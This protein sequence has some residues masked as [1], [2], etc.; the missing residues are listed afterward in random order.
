MAQYWFEAPITDQNEASTQW[1]N[2][3][4]GV[5]NQMELLDKPFHAMHTPEDQVHWLYAKVMR[6][7][8]ASDVQAAFLAV[9]QEMTELKEELDKV[10]NG[11]YVELYLDSIIAWIDANLQCLVS[12]IVKF[13]C[14]GLGD[15]GHFKA[16]IPETWRFLEFD[17]GMN[18][19]DSETYGHLI[20]KW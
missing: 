15:D 17:T 14:F 2:R 19:D 10:K 1:R 7:A 13:V 6:A 12:R 20:I 18:P 5:Q 8:D 4:P 9:R 11:E 16:Y 3:L